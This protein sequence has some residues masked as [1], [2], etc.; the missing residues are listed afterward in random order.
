MNIFRQFLQWLGI[1][2]DNNPT[3]DD[4]PK[5]IRTECIIARQRAVEW[6]RRSK[7]VIPTVPFVRVVLESKPLNGMAGWTPDSHTIHIWRG[8]LGS[9]EHEFRHTLCLATGLGG[10]EDVTK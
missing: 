3:Q 2:R 5:E 9:L 10:G 1:G 8:Q 6:F 7:G 4:F